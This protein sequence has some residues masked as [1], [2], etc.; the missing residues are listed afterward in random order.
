MCVV[1][2]V[3]KTAGLGVERPDFTVV[4]S[5]EDALAIVGEGNTV[6]LNIRNLNSKQFLSIVGVPNSDITEG[7]GGKHIRI[8]A[9][10]RDVIDLFIMAGVSQF[11]SQVFGINPVDIRQ[12]GA[13][14]E[15]AVV[16]SKSHRGHFAHDVGFACYKV[17]F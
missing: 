6:T 15:V 3:H 2:D 11:R 10:K 16:R 4:P 7:T 14:E 17:T 12:G 5:T 9:R 8:A 1:D 13:A